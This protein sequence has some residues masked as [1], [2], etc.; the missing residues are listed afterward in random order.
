M[1]DVQQFAEEVCKLAYPDGDPEGIIA[2][3]NKW[4]YKVVDIFGKL[5]PPKRGRN[6]VVCQWRLAGIDRNSL[7]HI[8]EDGINFE[9]AVSAKSVVALNAFHWA[10]TKKIRQEQGIRLSD[11]IGDVEEDE[12]V[13]RTTYETNRAIRVWGLTVNQRIVGM[14][15]LFDKDD[16]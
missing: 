9:L 4:Q 1:F 16:E 5:L 2:G 3:K 12:P 11:L 7:D 14:N 15:Y 6:F 13:G 10:L 8:S